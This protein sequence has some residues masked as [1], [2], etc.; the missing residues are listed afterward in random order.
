VLDERWDETT[1]E[2]ADGLATLLGG[3]CTPTTV[4]EAEASDDGR[5]PEL[6]S[7][8]AEFGLG[9]LP[10]V[11]VLLAAAAWELGR[12]L[13]PVPFP[14]TAAVRAVLDRGDVAY[15]AESA[16]P[17]GVPEALVAGRDGE[18]FV[19][20]VGGE[21]RRTAAGDFLRPAPGAPRDGTPDASADE[22][23][24][25]GRLVRLLDAA[26]LVGAAEGL[27]ALGVA[28]AGERRQFGRPIGSFQAIA[29]RLADAAI[30]TDGAGLLVR[31]AAWVA[32]GAR[33][34]DGAPDAVFAA[35]AR[36]KAV[37]A[38]RLVATHVHQ[39]MGGYGFALEYDCQLY[40]RRI[41]S[42]SMRLPR[43]ERE[44]AEVARVLLDPARRDRVRHLWNADQGVELPRWAA[45]VD[46]VE[47]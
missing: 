40:S 27:L 21:A 26:R 36:A 33:G 32:D 25:V 42:W 8:L 16:V 1:S 14:E 2:M 11:P 34:G 39:T 35:M 6:E 30:A 18:G 37:D 45:E 41:R 3:E 13:V 10:A 23:E 47:Q 5:S 9:E 7:R 38:G 19:V 20:P 22:V 4:R 28:Y 12:A 15:A 46:G 29:H 31:K 44:L 43:P 24:R 17:A